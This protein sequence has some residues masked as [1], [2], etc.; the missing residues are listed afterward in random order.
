MV[1][2]VL[3]YPDNSATQVAMTGSPRVR[4]LVAGI[5]A[6]EPGR[7]QHGKEDRRLHQAADPGRAG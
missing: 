7:P 5:K 4:L 6:F 1:G 2:W 3:D